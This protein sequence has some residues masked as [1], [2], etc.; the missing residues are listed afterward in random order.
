MRPAR[1]NASGKLSLRGW[2]RELG[3]EAATA[4]PLL[5]VL[6]VLEYDA[7]ESMLPSMFKG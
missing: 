7:E 5:E 4:G 2:V 1:L 3:G 6:R